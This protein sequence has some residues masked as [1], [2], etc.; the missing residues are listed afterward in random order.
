MRESLTAG[1]TGLSEGIPFP[2]DLLIYTPAGT[3]HVTFN[4]NRVP[5]TPKT[6]HSYWCLKDLI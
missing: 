3:Q 6:N 5:S 2:G 1:L 4:H